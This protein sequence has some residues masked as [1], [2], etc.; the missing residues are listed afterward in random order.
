MPLT[1][2]SICYNGNMPLC[3][4]RYSEQYRSNYFD[5]HGLSEFI[6]SEEYVTYVRNFVNGKLPQTCAGCTFCIPQEADA[7]KGHFGEFLKNTQSVYS[8]GS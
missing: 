7:I 8:A 4:F 6:A 5:V 2:M 3:A 1:T